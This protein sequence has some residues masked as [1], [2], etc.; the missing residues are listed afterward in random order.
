MF[1]GFK[2][3]RPWAAIILEL[4]FS[5][6]IAMLYLNRGRVALIYLAADFFIAVAVLAAVPIRIGHS[7]EP[8]IWLARIPL[9][10]FA[11]VHAYVISKNWSGVKQKHWYSRWY[12]LIGIFMAFPALALLIR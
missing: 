9:L 1:K 12:S 4:L 5:P 6:F 8:F 11:A 7:P 10:L 2:Q 3:R